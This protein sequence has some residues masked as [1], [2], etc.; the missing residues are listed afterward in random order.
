M[1]TRA[2]GGRSC[3][4]WM[5]LGMLGPEAPDL[6]APD[7]GEPALTLVFAFPGRRGAKRHCSSVSPGAALR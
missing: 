4:R 5:K 7:A 3:L 2:G 6:T 1:I